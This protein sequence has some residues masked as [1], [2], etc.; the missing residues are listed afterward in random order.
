MIKKIRR[1]FYNLLYS[2][3][4]GLKAADDEIFAQKASINSDNVGI[5]QVVQQNSLAK[6]LR[7]GEV[8]QQVEELRYRTYAVERESNNYN[9]LGEGVA[10]K[11]DI[12]KFNFNS[13]HIIQENKMVCNSVNDEMKRVDEKV[14]ANEE[15]TL[16]IV[17]NSIPRFKLEKYCTYFELV[18]NNGSFIFNMRFINAPNKNDISS[19]SFIKEIN[20]LVNNIGKE[21]DYSFINMIKF[22]TYK[23]VGDDE[24]IEYTLNNLDLTSITFSYD[25]KEFSLSFLVK[26]VNREDLTDKYYS[27]TMDEKYKNNEKKELVFNLGNTERVRHCGECGKEISVYDGDIT[28]ETY[29]IPLCQECLEK[30]LLLQNNFYNLNKE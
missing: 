21:N 20:R 1:L 30:T 2:L 4:F 17:Y 16:N 8:T 12:Q 14:Y 11:K 22:V 18:S 6:D 26:Y 3:P 24:L 13:F 15:Y 25:E 9:Y 23:C 7:K 19:Y 10:V 28:E 29:G 5:H 27:K